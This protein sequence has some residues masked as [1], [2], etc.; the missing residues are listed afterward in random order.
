MTSQK[1]KQCDA[2]RNIE[3]IYKQ[4]CILC[5]FLSVKFKYSVK[6]YILI[7]IC[8]LISLSKYLSLPHLIKVCMILSFPPHPFAYFLISGYLLRAPDN[9]PI[10]RT[11][12]GFPRRF[13]LSG[14]DCIAFF[15]G[16]WWLLMAMSWGICLKLNYSRHQ[17]KRTLLQSFPPLFSAFPFVKKSIKEFSVSFIKK[18]KSSTKKAERTSLRRRFLQIVDIFDKLPYFAELMLRVSDLIEKG[19]LNSLID[20]VSP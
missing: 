18:W 9:D 14:V 8:W 16:C 4:P 17:I 10:T 20:R 11:F 2:V 6:S 13:E 15:D 5:L 7:K 3:F 12:F 1:I 19:N